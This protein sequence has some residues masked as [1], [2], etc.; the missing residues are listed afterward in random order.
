MS[1]I[2]DV[3]LIGLLGLGVLAAGAG[4]GLWWVR[5]GKP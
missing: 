1:V 5:R 2:L 3:L 4:L